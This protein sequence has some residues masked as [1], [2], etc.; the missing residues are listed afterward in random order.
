[1]RRAV[2]PA[3][4][5]LALA[6]LTAS[7]TSTPPAPTVASL[8]ATPAS[9][10]SGSSATLSWTLGGGAPTDVTLDQ[11]IGTVSGKS[12]L[13]VSPA[14]TTTYT[15]TASNAG[16]HDSATATVTVTAPPAPSSY[17][18][19]VTGSH[20]QVSVDGSAHALP[21]NQSVTAGTSVDLRAI[22]D[23][24]Y[25]F[26]HWGDGLSGTT[27]PTSFAVT[28]DT[29]VSATFVASGADTTA[30]SVSL[31][32]PAA[33]AS[34][35]A[36]TITLAG[37][38]SD[39]VAVRTV[40]A[41]LNG[42]AAVTCAYSSPGFTCSV[43]T[44]AAGANSVT[45]VATD[46]SGN[47]ASVTRSVSYVA[48]SPTEPYTITLDFVSS[49]SASQKQAF[50]DA[51]A[52]WQ[53]VVTQG[54]PQVSWTIPKDSCG[55]N[56]D[57]PQADITTPIDDVRIDVKVVSI[58]GVGNIL[59][60]GGP[61]YTRQSDGLTLYGIMEFDSADL[62]NLEG[63]GLLNDTILHEMGHVLGIGTLW[64]PLLTGAGTD[65]PRFIGYNAVREW[66]AFGGS[67]DVPVENCID[68]SGN[69]MQNC[70]SGT[71]DG[72]WR[73]A[74]FGDELMTGYINAPPN[75]LSAMTV[76]SL[77]D[78]GYAVNYAAADAYTLASPVVAQ[79]V[80]GATN[81]HM[82]LIEPAGSAP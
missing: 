80:S 68:A 50:Q 17:T 59:G 73:E 49:I 23:T 20:G 24:G 63:H 4:A 39:N 44:L 21:Y 74:V 70:G 40:E 18:L 51:A 36:T 2:V 52:R 7:C 10:T 11:G 79:G 27:N 78:L 41:Q 75:P 82:V 54:L 28:G 15:L 64:G 66:H 46:S 38:A 42:G 77:A 37:T 60:F 62:S 5:L 6:L 12:Q 22:P 65:N 47:Q 25:S 33:G 16:G 32:S 45:V 8:T 69:A 9:I 3:L 48:P 55:P 43:G 61:C 35:G 56:R 13:S 1:M 81:L 72:H 29:S 71:R 26:D 67:G 30:P 31:A 58:D 76:G 14:V 34:V 19:T 57:L 53:Q